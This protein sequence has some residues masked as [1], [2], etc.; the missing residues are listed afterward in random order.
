MSKQKK[1][2]MV[3]RLAQLFVGGITV[4]TEAAEKF[5]AILVNGVND[6]ITSKVDAAEIWE[7]VV[8]EI[9]SMDLPKDE[10]RSKLTYLSS[11]GRLL[12]EYAA[13]LSKDAEWCA[14]LQAEANGLAKL[15]PLL[16]KGKAAKAARVAEAQKSAGSVF[17]KDIFPGGDDWRDNVSKEVAAMVDRFENDPE[18]LVKAATERRTELQSL[19][20]QFD[21]V[22]QYSVGIEWVALLTPHELLKQLGLK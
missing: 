16:K 2:T 13:N 17:G 10:K 21:T 8:V 20:A 11:K 7:G 15:E 18:G 12:F 5:S 1:Q 19:A 22:A 6:A 4:V 9:H 14:E 3:K